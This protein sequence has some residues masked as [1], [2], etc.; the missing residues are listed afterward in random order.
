MTS[1]SNSIIVREELKKE[2]PA[3]Y[4]LNVKKRRKIRDRRKKIKEKSKKQHYLFLQK[5]PMVPR[6]QVEEA[7]M[8]KKRWTPLFSSKSTLSWSHSSA[9]NGHGSFDWTKSSTIDVEALLHVESFNWLRI[10]AWQ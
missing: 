3:T 7:S 6:L 8:S 1:L 10:V 2:L 4:L 9:P 5:T